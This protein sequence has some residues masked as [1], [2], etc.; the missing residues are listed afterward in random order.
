MKNPEFK[1]GVFLV[2]QI[3]LILFN[4]LGVF[5][6]PWA[7]VFMPTWLPFLLFIGFMVV[8]MGIGLCRA[9]RKSREAA[10]SE[11]YHD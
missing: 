6:L 3:G 7:A 11:L 1:I 9:W 4:A 8:G 10:K 2:V 5:D